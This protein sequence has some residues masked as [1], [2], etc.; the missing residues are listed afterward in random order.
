MVLRGENRLGA[1]DCKGLVCLGCTIRPRKPCAE[2]VEARNAEGKREFEKKGAIFAA[3]KRAG[4]ELAK[5]VL[6]T[7]IHMFKCLSLVLYQY[8]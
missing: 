1:N 2:V 3:A 6:Y 4:P 8:K 7:L 5:G